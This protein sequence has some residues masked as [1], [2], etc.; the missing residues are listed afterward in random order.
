VNEKTPTQLLA[1]WRELERQ[2]D[3]TEPDGYD[4][5]VLE[6]EIARL[7]SEY[8]RV[9]T[10]A[11]GRFDQLSAASRNSFVRLGRSAAM[12][13]MSRDLLRDAH[14]RRPDPERRRKRSES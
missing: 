9:A 14:A 4:Y 1:A 8:H 12:S 7:R 13:E 2:Q 11:V 10:A 3:A 6:L 5:D